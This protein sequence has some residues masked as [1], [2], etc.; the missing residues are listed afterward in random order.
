MRE[1]VCD[2]LLAFP[3]V[4]M[5]LYPDIKSNKKLKKK[6]GLSDKMQKLNSN[7]QT[8]SV[9]S[10]WCFQGMKRGLVGFILMSIRQTN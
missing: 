5:Y 8:F 10:E 6:S 2:S 3:Y 4:Y 1:H 9:T 7:I